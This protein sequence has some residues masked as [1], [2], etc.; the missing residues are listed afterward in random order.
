VC[1][2]AVFAGVI[3]TLIERA[4]DNDEGVRT[5]IARAIFD[6]GLEQPEL[7]RSSSPPSR[8]PLHG[9]S[10]LTCSPPPPPLLRRLPSCSVLFCCGRG[11]VQTV[12]S[13]IVFVQRN[14]P[15]L[16]QAHR[17]ILLNLLVRILESKREKLT[18]ELGEN[19]VEFCVRE[20]VATK[21]D[22]PDWQQP[23]STCLV[24]QSQTFCNEVIDH[25]L[26]CFKPG[27]MPHFF[28]IKTMADIAAAH[29]IDGPHT[30]THAYT[31]VR[32]RAADW[33]TD[34]SVRCDVDGCVHAL[35]RLLSRRRSVYASHAGVSVASDSRAVRR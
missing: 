20:M 33:P 30:R 31:P 23:V 15:K 17:I 2:V 10:P 27:E 25:L 22:A 12:S 26:K 6:I 32:E 5:S 7:V 29:G 11:P 18:R 35:C 9:N 21:D 3:W 19:V 16:K 34:R 28:I 8:S 14:G 24:L 1:A 13:L 4:N